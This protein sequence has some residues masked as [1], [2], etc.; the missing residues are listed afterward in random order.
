MTALTYDVVAIGNAIVDIIGRC[1]DAF[2][3][4]HNCP[5]GHMRLVDDATITALYDDM[6]PSTEMSGGSAANTAVGIASFGG[7]AAFIGRVASDEFGRIFTHDIKAAGVTFDNKPAASGAPTS[8]SLILVTPDGERTMNTL[9]GS[10]TEL[11]E[12]EL[13]ANLIESAKV[14]YLEGYLFDPPAAKAAFRKAMAIAEKSGRK[15]ALSLSDAFC[16]D[17]HRA[18]FKQ[19]ILGNGNGCVDIVFANE[20]EITS[21]YETNDFAAAVKLAAGD[22]KLAVITCG[23][24]GSLILSAGQQITVPVDPVAKVVDSTGAGDLYAAG[25]LYGY[26]QGRDLATCGR[27]ASIAAAEIISHTGARPT[28]SLAS[29]ARTKG[30]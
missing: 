16:V 24:A 3:A 2:L 4:T 22:I 10:S 20:S 12:T 9:L 8:R 29:L 21:L 30:V 7:K 15:V 26:T 14:L 27:L 28:T 5:K 25:F 13:S 23:A 17:R 19:L 1:D 6:G 11:A 18:E